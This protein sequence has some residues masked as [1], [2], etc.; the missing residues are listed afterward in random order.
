MWSQHHGG[1]SAG[2]NAESAVRARSLR[3]LPLWCWW[4]PLV[5]VISLPWTGFTPHP[6]WDRVHWVPFSDPADRPRDFAANIALFVP[7]GFSLAGHRRTGRWIA[8]A[9]LAAAAV[10]LTA[11]ATQLFS[12]VRHPSA[13]DVSA[14]VAGA[15]A[16]AVWRFR[17][18]ERE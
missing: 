5:W 8:G 9:V 15:L 16:G 18:T 4:I 17:V 13:T 12:T 2:L 7:F 14:A 11:E 3:A 1:Y 6:Q 10:S